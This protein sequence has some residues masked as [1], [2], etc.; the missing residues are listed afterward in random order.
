M[1]LVPHFARNAHLWL[2][3]YWKAAAWKRSLPPP[4]TVWVTIAD[5][6]EPYWRKAD[7]ATAKRRVSEWREKW[8]RIA[9]RHKDSKGNPPQYTFFYAEEEYHPDCLDM[10][11][12]MV[13][14]G[15][16][17]VEVHLHHDHESAEDFVARLERF[18]RTLHQRHGLLREVDGRIVFGF[19]HGN[20]ALDNSRPDGRWCGLN[21]ELTLLRDLGCYADFT[22]PSAPNLTQTSIVNTIYQATDDPLR[23]KSHDSGERITTDHWP[24]G[25]LL[26]VPGPLGWNFRGG[27]LLPR[28]ETGE[29]AS[30]DLPVKG[31]ARS[32]IELAPQIG[33]QIFVKL[34][35]HGTQEHNASALLNSGLDA[36]FHY[37]AKETAEL[38]LKLQ[39]ASAWE[40]RCAIGAASK[41]NY[42]LS[43]SWVNTTLRNRF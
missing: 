26:M 5:H 1:N 39:F 3:G 14:E 38:G 19:I 27:R 30:Y 22:L 42:Q 32:W 15:I 40:M 37:L 24:S 16:G 8:P 35:A 9:A 21:N 36:C 18:K 12:S 11:S 10:L 25:D 7:E 4:S 23:P 34:F 29:I 43:Q 33:S 41:E 2:P 31:R 28:L 17:D 20:W 13:R 6:Y